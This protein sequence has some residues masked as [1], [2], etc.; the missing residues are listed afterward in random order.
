M[1][2]LSRLLALASCALATSA[3]RACTVCDSPNGHALRAGL[4]GG[5]PGHTLLLVLA[6]A[7]VL[8]ACAALLFWGMPDLPLPAAEDASP[9]PSG[10]GAP[11]A[12]AAC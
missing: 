12:E 6:P 11:Q 5:H 9:L 4:L 2:A 10:S 7:P 8:L 1:P 3:A